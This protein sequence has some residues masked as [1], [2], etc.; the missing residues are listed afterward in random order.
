MNGD[1]LTDLDYGDL[2]HAHAL[3]GAPLTVATAPRTGKIDFGVLEVDDGQDRR[4][5]RE[6]DADTTG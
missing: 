3:S 6:A 4:L 1:I 5:H 2:L